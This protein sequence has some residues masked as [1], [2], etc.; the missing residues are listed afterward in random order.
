M[1]LYNF[2]DS[3]IANEL[4]QYL[5][6]CISLRDVNV[7]IVKMLLVRYICEMLQICFSEEEQYM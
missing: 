1:C 6:N 5:P 2:V 3:S 7:F 4:S